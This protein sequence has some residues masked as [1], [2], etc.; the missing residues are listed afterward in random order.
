MMDDG[1]MV[2]MVAL[3]LPLACETDLGFVCWGEA[4]R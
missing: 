3:S 2:V 1:M 4:T